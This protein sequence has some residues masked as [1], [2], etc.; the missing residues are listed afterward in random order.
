MSKGSENFA[1]SDRF[2]EK[3]IKFK[4]AFDEYLRV[5]ESLANDGMNGS[6]QGIDG[7][8]SNE[9]LAGEDT[10]NEN[11]SKG[12]LRSS[13]H[14]KK[15]VVT[16]ESEDY[17]DDKIDSWDQN[18]HV[19]DK[20]VEN[21]GNWT[22]RVSNRGQV[23]SKQSR[24]NLGNVSREKHHV[25]S[26]RVSGNGKMG[27]KSKTPF[28]EDRRLRL[29]P[30]E[31]DIGVKKINGYFELRKLG[32][33]N[34]DSSIA[35]KNGKWTEG[36]VDS[37]KAGNLGIDKSKDNVNRKGH[38]G[39]FYVLGK[40]ASPVTI[41]EGVHA[42][43]KD[44]T[45]MQKKQQQKDG[46]LAKS[47]INNTKRKMDMDKLVMRQR[48]VFTMQD[49][50][51]KKSEVYKGR[52]KQDSSIAIDDETN[53]DKCNN[54]N[55]TVEG[56][57][58]AGSMNDEKANCIRRNINEIES[59]DDDDEV[60]ADEIE[61]NADSHDR[62]IQTWGSHDDEK[63]IHAQYNT[64]T[65]AW[66]HEDVA[67]VRKRDHTNS[68]RHGISSG[69]YVQTKKNEKVRSSGQLSVEDDN[70]SGLWM[71]RKA[72]ETFEVFTDVRNRPRVLRME[73]EERIKKLAK[74]LNGM[75]V[76]VPEWKFSK[77][78]HSAK[79]KFTDH[80]ILRVIQILGD[81][82]NW[83]KALQVV[84]WLHS[85]ERFKSYKSKYIYTTVLDVLGKARRPVEALNVFHAMRRQ[86]S[87]YPDLAAYHCI[88]VT[89]GQAGY[90]KELFDVIDCMRTLPEKKFN[91]GMLTK[92]DPRL[93]PDIFI[94]NAVMLECGKYN[95]VHEFFQKVEKNSIPSALNYKVLVNALW[96][97]GKTD[98]AVLAVQDMERR[99]VVGSASLYYDLARCLCSAGRC[100]EALQQ[101]DKICKVAKK[102]LVVTYTGLMQA[103]LDSGNVQNGAYIFNHMQKFCSPNIV[104]HN[105]ILKAYTEH[106]MIEEAKHLFQKL[107]EGRDGESSE[108]N[109]KDRVLPDR[110]TFN[111]MLEAC[112]YGRRWDDF[113]RIYKQML[114]HGYHFNP[115]RHL[116]MILE[117]SKAGQGQMVD[118]TW[119]RLVQSGQPLPLP[120]MKERF[121]LKLHEGNISE[122]LSCIIDYQTTEPHTISEKV[123]LNLFNDNAFR[124]RKDTLAALVDKFTTVTESDGP[125]SRFE[126]LVSSCE[127]FIK[128]QSEVVDSF[129]LGIR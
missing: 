104:T 72:F 7:Y 23:G 9:S 81:L 114:H 73:M 70:L 53:L 44:M 91:L 22:Q 94:Y 2:I 77:M 18:L 92:W 17:P 102:P 45:N 6:S 66:L 4:P 10:C 126:N 75:N 60:Y 14:H 63:E 110:F 25:I 99:G 21:D 127:K 112:I 119:D 46:R 118:V 50:K 48:T 83:R 59:D 49:G 76:N 52:L 24:R 74:S 111:T 79:I 5:M 109:A 54:D 62:E 37:E 71:E 47:Q 32:N 67:R 1:V 42:Y 117:A 36:E 96:R 85:H 116:R 90:M 29:Y 78:M 86:L 33:S 20:L 82:G 64:Q 30:K 61:I 124:I 19:S 27:S 123:W 95:L 34:V 41:S 68:E 98:E 13:S 57:H 84:E 80:S 88:A 3:E 120:L 106:G 103:C 56:V 35:Q 43:N 100:K 15:N 89:L 115:K 11:A 16:V 125:D 107:L 51:N 38:D 97:E 58:W 8:H 128:T 28:G 31:D 101:V 55:Y 40:G 39:K 65:R 105:I 113:E 129:S 108:N 12:R 93:E 122:A 87:S 69:E 26:D 121:C